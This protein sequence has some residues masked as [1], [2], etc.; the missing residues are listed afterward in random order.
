[1]KKWKIMISGFGS[2]GYHVAGFLE[3]RRE[4][5]RQKYGADVQLVAVCK[6]RSGIYDPEGLTLTEI[7]E[8]RNGTVTDKES[9]E[10][11]G[12]GFVAQAGIDVLIEAGPTNF[13]HGEP[14]MSYLRSALQKHIHAIAI[15][16]G[17]LVLDY[18]GL[19][20]LAKQHHVMLKISG[21]TAAALPTIDLLEYNLAGCEVKSMSGIFTGT[22]NFIL[23]KM[24][25]EQL[26]F[27]EAVALAQQMGI[28]EPNPQ[29]DIDG[30]D[31]ACK[32]TILA[33]AAFETAVQLKDVKREG[34][35]PIT[36]DELAQYR[37]QNVV[38]KLIGSIVRT[39]QGVTV[40]VKKELL[41]VDHPLA[42]VKGTTKAVYVETD[43]MGDFLVV[44]GKSDPRAAAAA[45]LKD[46]EHILQ[47]HN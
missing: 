28:A 29:F 6:S 27:E 38:P 45:A 46:L 43:V 31:T 32:M 21:A 42:Q 3:A 47:K 41:P 14:G 16:K 24:V 1:M 8:F 13:E 5:Y 20:T 37:E 35:G 10:Y 15:S 17:A 9:A 33:N 12:A 34:I 23:T 25:D 30:W 11:T 7:E 36:S 22:T 4:H 44:G 40:Q 26:S 19:S 18:Q 2:V 39:E